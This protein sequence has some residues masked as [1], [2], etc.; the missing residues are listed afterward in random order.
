LK[1]EITF[2]ILN[3]LYEL[4][5]VFMFVV[6]GLGRESCVTSAVVSPPNL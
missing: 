3:P 1:D 5:L 2:D 4:V 6:T